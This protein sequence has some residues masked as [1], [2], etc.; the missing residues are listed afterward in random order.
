MF[1]K[2]GHLALVIST[3]QVNVTG[4]KMSASASRLIFQTLVNLFKQRK[5]EMMVRSLKGCDNLQIV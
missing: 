2:Q 3:L 5:L 1:D 4:Y